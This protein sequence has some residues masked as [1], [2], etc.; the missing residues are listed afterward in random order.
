[1]RRYLH[2]S[3]FA[4]SIAAMGCGQAKLPAES[5]TP[6]QS[7]VAPAELLAPA[8]SETTVI[9]TREPG[10]QTPLVA[11]AAV[12]SAE[13][14]FQQTLIA[15]QE[16]RIDTAFEFLPAS[17][18]AD[19]ENLVHEFAEKMDAELWSKSF[20]LLTKVASI[21]RTKKSLILGMENVKRVSQLD[22]VKP[23]WDAIAQ[24]I[25][26][27]ATSEVADLNRL[28][29]CYLKSLLAS[30]SQL[31]NGMPLPKFGDVTVRTIRSD[32]EVATLSYL[33]SKESEPKEVEFVKIEGKWL[34]KNIA[35]GW[36]AGV[37]DA[38][39][40]IA[41]LPGQIAPIKP[42]LL[43][44]LDGISGMLNQLQQAKTSE[45]FNVAVMPLVL[46]IALGKGLA[47]QAMREAP[48]KPRAGSSMHLII[49]RELND[50]Q[51]T[52]LKDAI[53]AAINDSTAEY[54]IISN[55]G[56]T[57]L[58]FTQVS[59][60]HS[61]AEVLRKQFEGAAVVEEAE[62]KTIRVELK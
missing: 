8:K 19:V 59:D 42:V 48:T 33:E 6:K 35:T 40:K 21:L 53:L 62:T 24:G 58:R 28:K 1:M 2:L 54:E 57:R 32:A 29:G 12:G 46:S 11:T 55:D 45:E 41:S 39:S 3:I 30:G 20:E 27:V 10:T 44:Q 14:T 26:E 4:F 47:E 52:E 60:L 25:H 50:A 23:H 43:E 31:L 5:S 38:R 37:S 15:F 34:P 61:I 36:S 9:P 17:Y 16:G 22:A 51:Q 18:Q 13:A 56:K 49:D 7:V